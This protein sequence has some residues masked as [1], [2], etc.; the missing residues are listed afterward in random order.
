MYLISNN[1]DELVCLNED[2]EELFFKLDPGR[3]DVYEKVK[4]TIEKGQDEGKDVYV[5]V[6]EGPMKKGDNIEVLQIVIE[7]KAVLPPQ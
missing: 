4:E 7:A 3:A 5:T 1:L 6:L 2:Y